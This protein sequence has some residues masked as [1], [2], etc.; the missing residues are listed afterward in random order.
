MQLFCLYI[1]I[2]SIIHI[3]SLFYL[4]SVSFILGLTN[5]SSCATHITLS[6]FIQ[7]HLKKTFAIHEA[8][9]KKC[10]SN[11]KSLLY[12]NNICWQSCYIFAQVYLIG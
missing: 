8:D 5:F 6:S 4:I 9:R 10:V 7:D 3:L 2:W 1:L 12:L 11:K